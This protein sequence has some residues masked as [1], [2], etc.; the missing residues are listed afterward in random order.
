[1]VPYRNV[2]KDRIIDGV[3]QLDFLLGKQKKSNREGFP[4]YNGDDMFAYKWR[5]WKVHL[6][7]QENPFDPPL[8][9]NM[10]AVYNLIADPKELYDTVPRGFSAS[11]VMPAVFEKIVK[12]Q[13][14]LIQEPP[15]PLGTPDPYEPPK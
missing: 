14:T 5:N 15:I 2:P 3:D 9:L 1:M 6:V 10:P 7:Q 8:K 4:A 12:F 13:K 11:W